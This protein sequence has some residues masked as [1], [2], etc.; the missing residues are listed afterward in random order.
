M[1]VQDIM[2]RSIITISEDTPVKEIGRL[3]FSLGIAGL[4]VVKDKKLIGI[5]TEK[6]ILARF[7]PSI[8]EYMEDPIHASDFEKMEESLGD[9]LNVPAKTIMSKNLISASPNTPL[10]KAHSL[11]VL[12][13]I[14]RLP[15]V[16]KNMEILG[17]VSQGDIFRQ[18]VKKEIPKLEKER[19]AG[20][21][22]RY[23]DLMVNWKKRFAGEFPTL[24]KL[25]KK[26]KVKTVLDVGVWTGEYTIGLV[27]KGVK[28]LGLDSHH[29]MVNISEEKR[30]KLSESVRKNVSFMLTDYS[31]FSKKIEDKFDA[32]ICMGNSLSYVPTQLPIL[33]REVYNSLKDDAV[34]ILQ[35]LNFEKV[36][37][38]KNRLLSFIIQKGDKGE[39]LFIEF[40]DK[41]KDDKL[42]HHVI[43]FD[44]DGENWIYKGTTSI[45]IYDIRKN[46]I[47]K[48]LK[49]AGF[50]K[51]SFSGNVGEYQGE[52]GKLS[53]NA[54]FDPLQSDWLNVVARR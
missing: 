52:Y 39:H 43:I 34:L 23:Y 12:N 20:F 49:K 31:D 8:Q 33:F 17:I 10:I 47:E 16:D 45:P 3:I 14:S 40:F 41:L 21:I 27:K 42:T 46:A 7:H 18:L 9:F 15:I 53:F 6:D 11:M 2:R 1:K 54:P 51:I 5:V 4:P 48:I 36:L 25:F 22:A 28:V 37:K 29:I 50:R 26:Y 38:T 13:K 19:Y 35:L 24:L 32:A 44:S 30:K